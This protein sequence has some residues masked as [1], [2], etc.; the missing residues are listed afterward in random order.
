MSY[1]NIQAALDDFTPLNEQQEG[2]KDY[3]S[4]EFSRVDR[5]VKS[6]DDQFFELR[7]WASERFHVDT[8][9]LLLAMPTKTFSAA[10]IKIVEDALREAQRTAREKQPTS[11]ME[12]TT[13]EVEALIEKAQV[14]LDKVIKAGEQFIGGTK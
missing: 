11:P 1:E 3:L 2:V 7:R 8:N 6:N 4:E 5:H 9:K 14:A 13:R 10:L 12:D